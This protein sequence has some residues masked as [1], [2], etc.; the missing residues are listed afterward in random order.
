MRVD[1]A[2]STSNVRRPVLRGHAT[3]AA[4]H[5]LCHT[6]AAACDAAATARILFH[7]CSG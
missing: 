6:A 3:L 4:A 5:A 2:A 1:D 7:T